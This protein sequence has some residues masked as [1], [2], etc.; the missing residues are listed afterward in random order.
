MKVAK[1]RRPALRRWLGATTFLPSR[2]CRRFR[3]RG[4]QVQE[5]TPA[6]HGSAVIRVKHQ[7]RML[8]R[9]LKTEE[10]QR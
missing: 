5:A 8:A 9:P 6:E 7:R 10:I 3:P 4:K 2:G 1:A